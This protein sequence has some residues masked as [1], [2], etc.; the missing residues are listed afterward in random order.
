MCACDYV[1]LTQCHRNTATFTA[2]NGFTSSISLCNCSISA[3]YYHTQTAREGAENADGKS[4]YA[5]A[6]ES[7]KRDMFAL[8][9]NKDYVL[10]L[11]S[12]SIGVG[13][14]N[15]LL[16]LLNQIVNPFGY[17]YK[18][19]HLNTVYCRMF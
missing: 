12:F 6:I 11:M 15:A 1:I 8:F 17:R 5:R 14:F 3:A 4:D 10:L 13:F 7:F 19:R 18:M 16:T 9:S 2:L